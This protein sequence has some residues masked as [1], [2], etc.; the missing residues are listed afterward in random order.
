MRSS[1]VFVTVIWV[2]RY[3]GCRTP[4]PP[5]PLGGGEGRALGAA[6]VDGGTAGV[7]TVRHRLDV[8]EHDVR[9]PGRVGVAPPQE[10]LQALAARGPVQ[11]GDGGSDE[12][13]GGGAD[14]IDHGARR[15]EDRPP[16]RRGCR[17]W[18]RPII[19]APRRRPRIAALSSRR[20]GGFLGWGDVGAA[21]LEDGD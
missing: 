13:A 2:T 9:G 20:A 16:G 3:P 1:E 12:D 14:A 19:R 21:R 5:R 11:L 15:H 17:S 18:N 10:T 6:P 7:L 8:G 4:K